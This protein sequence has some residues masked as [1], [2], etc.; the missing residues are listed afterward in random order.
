[1]PLKYLIT[2]ATGGLGALVLQHL[3]ANASVPPTTYAAAS[4]NPDRS[5]SFTSRG[6]QFR[7][8]DFSS[9]SSLHSA[10]AD[11]KNLLF[12]STN[13]LDHA[14]RQRQ[15]ANVVEAAK[16]AGVGHVWYT[17]LAF[18]GYGDDSKALFQIAHLETERLLRESGLAF[19]SLRMGCYADAWPLFLNWYPEQRKGVKVPADGGQAFVARE[20]LA[21]ATTNLLLKGAPGDLSPGTETSGGR[22]LLLTGP[23]A[24]TLQDV[25]N[26]AN[27]VLSELG[28]DKITYE[29]VSQE[30]YVEANS[31]A[32]EG[33]KPRA[34]FE[35]ML[36]HYE[37]IAAADLETVDPLL[38]EV[39][40]RR[41]M[42][43]GELVRKVMKDTAGQYTWHQNYRAN[44]ES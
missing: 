22:T 28:K 13:T 14:L 41:P 3:Q 25:V 7:H 16:R 43:G 11:V 5:S 20:E 38:E 9:P 1:M 35:A 2:G 17:S 4:S 18:G 8:A 23:N 42:D 26:A 27:S 15:H 36:S 31:D 34:F 37:A 19:T 29:I 33:G 30:E 44:L 39:L 24:M 6:I 32:D 10:F 12:V 40:G 21:E